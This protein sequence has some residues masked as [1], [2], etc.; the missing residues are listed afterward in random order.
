VRGLRA[1][2]NQSLTTIASRW[3]RALERCV[4]A[5]D[6]TAARPL[7]AID[8][9]SF[10][11][12]KPVVRGRLALERGQWARVWPR[13]RNFTFRLSQMCC[14]G[15]DAGLCIIVPWT[16]LGVG[17][18]GRTFSRPGRATVFLVPQRGRWVALHSH[19]S[20]A[21]RVGASGPAKPRRRR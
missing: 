13:I 10:G 7:F 6:Y 2:E 12:Y 18:G 16:S 5:V 19:F 1:G 17:P 14:V 8:T 3:L 21:P 4:R 15:N 9:Y 20:L 11:T